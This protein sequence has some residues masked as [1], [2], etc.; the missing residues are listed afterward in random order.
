[1][2]MNMHAHMCCRVTVLKTNL[3]LNK[4]YMEVLNKFLSKNYES[5]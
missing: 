1:M 4:V 3:E 5:T 2:L